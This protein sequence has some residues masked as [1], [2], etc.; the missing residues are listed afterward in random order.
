MRRKIIIASVVVL[1]AII[2][3]Y[4]YEMYPFAKG[5]QNDAKKRKEFFENKAKSADSVYF[6]QTDTTNSN[7]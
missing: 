3:Y 7:H 6:I 5:V 4:A 2:S 1:I